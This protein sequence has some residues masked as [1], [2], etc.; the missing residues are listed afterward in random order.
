M[1]D[2]PRK[3]KRPTLLD[4]A[5]FGRQVLLSFSLLMQLTLMAA[6]L[7]PAAWLVL[8]FKD[9]ATS[10]LHWVLLILA[11]VL[12]FNYGYL[13]GLLLLRVVIPRPKE[14]SY[15][16]ELGVHIPREV[17]VYMFNLLLTKARYEPP[18]AASF[19]A[20]LSNLPPMRT[21]YAHL[22]G[23]KSKSLTT[24]DTC[25]I[26]DPSLI[27]IGSNVQLGLHCTIAAHVFDNRKLRIRKVR[28]GDGVLIGAEAGLFAGVQVGE[29]AVI[30]ARAVVMPFT[31]IGPYEFWD[32]NPA[33]RIKSLKPGEQPST[34]GDIAPAPDADSEAD[35][36]AD[37]V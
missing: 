18:W 4:Q 31:K 13:I 36:D 37:R 2:T 7:W 32:G 22:F 23:P 3:R 17:K 8:H 27:E 11:T 14:G 1:S 20:P 24:G 29:G 9:A 35:T 26:I 34:L 6:G 10:P 19:S 5:N 33:R 16:V 28:I 30:A 15:A 21:L 12:V 25:Y